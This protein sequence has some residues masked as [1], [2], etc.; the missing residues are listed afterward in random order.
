MIQ[1]S[2]LFR[3]KFYGVRGS[4]P[5]PST[6][7]LQYGGN[8]ACVE[9]RAGQHII[10]ID[11]GTGIIN[12]GE[13]LLKEFISTGTN[14]QN[15]DPLI[16]TMLFSHSHHDHLQG[17]PFFKP[18]FI[19]TTELYI[20]GAK[21]ETYG[22]EETLCRSMQ[23]PYFPVE[24]KEMG[25]TSKI[26]DLCQKHTI[27]LPSD[28]KRPRYMECD[29]ASIPKDAVIIESMKSYAHPKD[30]VMIF[31]ISWKGKSVV[32][33]SDKECYQE[34]DPRLTHFIKGTD[35][36]IHDT[37]YT[38]EDYKSHV[39]PKHGYGHSTPEMA[40]SVAK[41]AEVGKLLLFHYDPSYSDDFVK[42]IEHNTK[43]L[44]PNTIASYEGLEINL[45][46][47]EN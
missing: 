36:L 11:G 39:I 42:K 38:S 19:K 16:L 35:L 41:S 28:T 5:S 8:T 1:A 10:I 23:S 26:Q 3:V 2:D 47:D 21:N 9:V 4:H 34:G 24:L 14:L 20:F 43:K 15:R 18:G 6:K 29:K 22:F 40:V 31:K 45:F 33:A 37:Q 46:E 17:F 32:Y 12:L 30:G 13:D 44:F 25:A 7:T 27:I